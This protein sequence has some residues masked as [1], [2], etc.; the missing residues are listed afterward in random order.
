MPKDDDAAPP[1]R[2][3]RGLRIALAISVALNLAVA[4]LVIGVV[5][6]GPPMPPMAVRDLGFGPFAGALTD[7]DRRVLRDA[8]LARKPDLRAERR[9]MRA[10]LAAVSGAL[11]ADPFVPEV[12]QAALER[13][14]ARTVDL[15]KVGQGLLLDHVLSMTPEARHA[16][17][18]RLDAAMAR[19]PRG[20][21]NPD[22]RGE[23]GRGEESP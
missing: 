21:R 4:G 19:G 11:R 23:D 2:G 15:L 10:D 20:G 22:A 16:L 5:L 1:V 6:K 3:N 7:D 14:A 8:F 12:L 17:A 9:A 18:D 13:G